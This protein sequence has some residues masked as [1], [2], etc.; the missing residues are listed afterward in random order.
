MS[1]GRSVLCAAAV[2]D[3]LRVRLDDG[4]EESIDHLLMATGYKIDIT[5]YDFLSQG[6]LARVNT[7]SGYP[8]LSKG[9]E[10]SL[11]GLHFLGAP[12]AWSFGP[13]MRFVA[14]ADFATRR[15]AHYVSTRRPFRPV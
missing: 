8:I 3:K 4:N 7:A 6:L 14:G 13:L 15:L 2:G 5:K 10:S 11:P 12:A 1:T 9:F